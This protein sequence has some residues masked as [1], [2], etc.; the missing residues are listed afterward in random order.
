MNIQLTQKEG[1]KE[2]AENGKQKGENTQLYQYYI[3]YK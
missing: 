2:G 3:K 1:G